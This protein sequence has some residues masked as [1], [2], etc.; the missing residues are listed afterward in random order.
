MSSSYIPFRS[1]HQKL[2]LILLL[3]KDKTFYGKM[4]VRVLPLCLFEKLKLCG[5]WLVHAINS[6]RRIPPWNLLRDISALCK[7]VS[8]LRLESIASVSVWMRY[9]GWYP[10]R[11]GCTAA[12]EENP[13]LFVYIILY[14]NR[15]CYY[16][17]KSYLDNKP[18][19]VSIYV[20]EWILSE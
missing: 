20:S 17:R 9:L 19:L 18:T 13:L 3:F 5:N 16:W 6:L 7:F 10:C 12:L 8:S 4:Q 11:I 2:K 15:T 14:R 1:I